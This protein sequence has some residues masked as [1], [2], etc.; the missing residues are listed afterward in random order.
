MAKRTKLV[1]NAQQ[2]LSNNQFQTFTFN[3][4]PLVRND[5]MAGKDYLVVP[6]VML[7]EGVHAGSNG[8]LYY[9]AEEI[10]K[11]PAIWNH[12]PLVVYH[13]NGSACDP[14]VITNRGIGLIMNAKTAKEKDPKDSKKK[15]VKLK[16]EAWI[17]PER[18]K[19]VDNRI[20]E[21]IENKQVL[22]VSTG[23]FTDNE[24][25]QG[26]WNGEEYIAIARNFRPDHLAILPDQKGACS[27]EDGAGFLRLNAA[28]GELELNVTDL[29]KKIETHAVAF[30]PYLN[31]LIENELSFDDI[32]M[33]LNTKLR[34]KV[35]N[36]WVNEVYDSHFIYCDDAGKYFSQDYQLKN[37]KVSLEGLPT[38]VTRKTVYEPVTNET[39]N[40]KGLTMKEKI[41][42]ELISNA[43][44][45]WTESD[46]DYLMGLDEKVL[47]KMSPVASADPNKGKDDKGTQADPT[48]NAAA[49]APE[50]A[51]AKP[52]TVN[53]YID[54]APKEMQDVLRNGMTAYNAEK[55]KFIAAITANK[56]NKFTKEQ[57]EAK[58]LDELKNLAALAAS[59]VPPQAPV[60]P[61][62]GGQADG[63]DVT[64]N[65]EEEPLEAPT[66]NFGETKTEK[67]D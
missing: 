63:A 3:L 13:P 7:T 12:K 57:L 39:K 32:R 4:S 49:K 17:E 15:I 66:M 33:L 52:Q 43:A 31:R 45:Q 44:T 56:A 58:P 6:M 19:V 14:D 22:E 53:E 16:A 42:N 18:A 2:K 60:Q 50:A 8:P 40:R 5:Q 9:P 29:R 24:D 64:A 47:A 36:A 62:Y 48:K 23:L 26:D 25:V 21:A 10:E 35:E 34:E 61:F 27:V 11:I 67:K 65:A 38:E 51:P 54:A 30:I 28:K 20:L 37:G 55:A 41:V 59:H 1:K 46:R